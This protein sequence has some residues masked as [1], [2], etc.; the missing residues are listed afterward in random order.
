MNVE[1]KPGR[2]WLSQHEG[3]RRFISLQKISNFIILGPV[4]AAMGI[5]TAA[6]SSWN[7]C[8]VDAQSVNNMK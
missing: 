3:K 4:I 5:G 1:K 6:N 2:V 7:R 8:F